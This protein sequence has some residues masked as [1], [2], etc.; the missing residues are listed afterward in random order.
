MLAASRQD[1]VEDIGG[2][3]VAKASNDRPLVFKQ[4][5][6]RLMKFPKPACKFRQPG[7]SQARSRSDDVRDNWTAENELSLPSSR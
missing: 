7:K 2:S 4:K 1:G 3:F 5:K 6:R